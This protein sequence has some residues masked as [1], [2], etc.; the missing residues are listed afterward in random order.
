MQNIFRQ[1]Y[2]GR[3]TIPNILIFLLIFINFV[4]FPPKGPIRF[5]P[6]NLIYFFVILY[7]LFNFKSVLNSKIDFSVILLF[8][9]FFSLEFSINSFQGEP[10]RNFFPRIKSTILIFFI[11][12]FCRNEN[13]FMRMI[14]FFVLIA[15]FNVLFGLLVFFIG[16]PFISIRIWFNEW[17]GTTI[18]IGKGSQLAGLYGM[19][20]VFGY[21][22]SAVPILCFTLYINEKKIFWLFCLLICSVGLLLN[23]ERSA[24]LMNIIVF[25]I[26][27]LRQ[28]NRILLFF[29]FALC[30]CFVMI[31][32]H[33]IVAPAQD[34]V[35]ADEA[36]YRAGSLTDRLKSTT[37]GEVFDRVKWSFYGIKTV[38][39]YPLT[40]GTEADYAHEVYGDTS[41]VPT[42][43][44]IEDTLASH[45]H[46]VN[47]G[48]KAGILGWII[49]ILLL[50]RIVTLLRMDPSLFTDNQSFV[51]IIFGVKLALFAA[52]GNAFFH[53]NGIMNSDPA[54]SWMLAFLMAACSILHTH[55]PTI[56]GHAE[57]H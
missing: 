7:I 6:E 26:L 35:H 32:Q 18:R 11:A 45:N 53:N 56:G 52:L 19:P 47:T 2:H 8:L 16:E 50:W 22:L 44:Q 51:T 13:D 55:Q 39:K 12:V 40:G 57:Y 36:S 37:S 28:R 17:S 27:I 15:T 29:L 42:Q 1:Q 43:S 41:Y 25:L 54:A 46:Y 10:L 31:I 24:L 3:N 9:L 20:H 38:L 21:I 34:I 49:V 14:K 23:A 4:P 33:Q 5:A 48:L 30:T